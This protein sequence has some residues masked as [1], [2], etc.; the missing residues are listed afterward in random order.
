MFTK[1]IKD[2]Y[3]TFH[4]DG[5]IGIEVLGEKDC[6]DADKLFTA[7][8][9]AKIVANNCRVEDYI[10]DYFSILDKWRLLAKPK[11]AK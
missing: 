8:L 10:D 5:A 6:I 1:R 2:I 3:L 11:I 4:S 9:Q 7:I